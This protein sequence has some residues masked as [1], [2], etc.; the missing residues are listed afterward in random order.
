MFR[1]KPLTATRKQKKFLNQSNFFIYVT[2][3]KTGCVKIDILT[4][5]IL[6]L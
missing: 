6:V 3:T 5:P 1:E 2:Y 4:H